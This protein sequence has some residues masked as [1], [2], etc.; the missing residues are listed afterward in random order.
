MP[1]RRRPT[2][3]IEAANR[4]SDEEFVRDYLQS[5]PAWSSEWMHP[6][7]GAK[8]SL[9]LSRTS[10]L[11]DDDLKGCFNLVEETS[12][13]DYR[14]SAGGWHPREKKTEMASEDLRYILVKDNSGDLRAFTS[15]M[16]C[17][18]E[19][20]PVVYCY[21]IHLK[22]EL[23]GC[24]LGKLMIGFLV[25]VAENLPPITKVMLTS[26][27]SNEQALKFY[28]GMGF[29][30]DAISPEPRKLRYGK[31]FSPDYV[32]MSKGV[33]GQSREI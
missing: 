6:N 20:E 19:G 14:S 10:A 8:Y 25:T 31:V 1:R 13:A 30:K 28:K 16:P 26:F 33:R 23:R 11:S 29:E 9:Q 32:I 27:L 12:G 24:G 18:E 2:G 5:S 4:K 17:F 7:T 3:P 21:E 15:L 22:P